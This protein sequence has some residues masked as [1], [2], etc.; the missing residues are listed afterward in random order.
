MRGI[1]VAPLD[2]RLEALSIPEP[3]SGCWLWLGHLKD[4]DYGTLAVKIDGIW[5]TQLAHRVSYET[6]RGPI[7]DGMDLDHKCRNRSCINP[8]HLEPVTRSEN[9]RRSPLMGF[10][11]GRKVRCPKGHPYSGTNNRG[12]RICKVCMAAAQARSR[13]RKNDVR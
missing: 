4:N 7:P 8:D 10:S 2:E 13:K 3:N 9:L 5:R 12:Q 6:S 11:M 1:S